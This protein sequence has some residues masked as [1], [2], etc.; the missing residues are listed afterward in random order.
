MSTIATIVVVVACIGAIVSWVVG[1]LNFVLTLRVLS[2]ESNRKQMWYAV[3][4]WPFASRQMTGEAAVY[5]SK[6]NKSLVAF[7]T[8]L[9]IAAA[10]MSLA[11]NLSRLS[12]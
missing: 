7:F 8:C 2:G 6:A 4:A 12:R 10:A 1:A 11:T 5:S 3:V 9:M